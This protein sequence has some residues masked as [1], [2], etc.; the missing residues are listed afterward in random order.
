MI[1]STR[2]WLCLIVAAS[3]LMAAPAASLAQA[4]IDAPDGATHVLDVTAVDYAFRAPDEIVSGWT[5]IRFTNEGEEPHFVFVSR[6]PEG[7]TIEDY[8]SRLSAPFS[9]A[10]YAVRDGRASPD[11]ALDQLF[12]ELPE[13]FPAVELLGGPGLTG[14]GRT[15]RMTMKLEPGNYVLECYAK[16]ADGEIHYM[17]GMIR[18]LVVRTARSDAAPPTADIRITLS[19]FE[20]AI[21]GEPGRGPHTVAVHAAENPE[22]GWGHSVHLARL[23]PGT[24]VSEVVRWMNWFEIDGLRTP[25]PAQF[26]GGVHA[27]P[28]GHTAYFDVDLEPGRYLLLSEA[29]GHL[30]VLREFTVR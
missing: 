28:E 5:T 6:L 17:E 23:D 12:A 4:P 3:T 10:W 25:A 30:G 11:E 16:T 18:P 27:M 21:D 22:V 1:P 29:T 26:L 8:E 24:D 14:P 20:M 19:N 13:W 2:T 9:R 15:T 7:K